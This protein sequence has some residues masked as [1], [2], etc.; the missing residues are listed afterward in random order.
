[1]PF[2]GNSCDEHVGK[3]AAMTLK[4]PPG[5]NLR[6]NVP[7]EHRENTFRALDSVDTIGGHVQPSIFAESDSV[8]T[9]QVPVH[10]INV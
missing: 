5:C 2:K 9:S 10:C 8:S 4:E 1:M 7:K 6:N 3:V